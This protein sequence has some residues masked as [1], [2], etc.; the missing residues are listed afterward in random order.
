MDDNEYETYE[1][2]VYK[3]MAGKICHKTVG[4]PIGIELQI[5]FTIYTYTQTHI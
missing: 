5:Y 4:T 1:Y 3:H 2:R